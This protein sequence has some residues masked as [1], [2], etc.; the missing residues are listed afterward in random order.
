MAGNIPSWP[1][2]VGKGK[3][4]QNCAARAVAKPAMGLPIGENAS[5]LWSDRVPYRLCRGLGV[6]GNQLIARD[7]Q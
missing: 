5:H 7:V 4:V 6:A 2:F 3:A 1:F